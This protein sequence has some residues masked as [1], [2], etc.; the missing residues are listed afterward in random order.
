MP[1]IVDIIC[2]GKNMMNY[3]PDMDS[4]R[5]RINASI[6]VNDKYTISVH[7]VSNAVLHKKKGKGDGHEGLCSD[8]IINAPHS[9]FV[10][11]T[12]IYNAM[13]VHGLS[14]DSMIL[15][16]MVPIPK[17]RCQSMVDS[18]N[19]RAITL[20]SIMGK[21][22]DWVV[23]LKESAALVSSDLQF[24]FK[25]GVST[26]QCSFLMLETISHY[27]YNGSN[28]NVLLLDATKAFDRV[29]YCKLFKLLIDKGMSPIV[30]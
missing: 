12:L 7:D 25:Q 8:N 22:L 30:I 19:Y 17:N 26:T 20:S 5:E 23:L 27:N 3:K 4:L 14:P 28:V 21:V 9:L 10:I 18:N 11:L 13:L 24:G 29:H 16:T 2:L 1:Q 6:N 15:G